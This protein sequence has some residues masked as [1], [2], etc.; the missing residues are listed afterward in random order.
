LRSN[1]LST[2]N[3]GQVVGYKLGAL[4]GSSVLFGFH[5]LYGWSGLY[6]SLALIYALATVLF[7]RIF[8]SNNNYIKETNDLS[9]NERL[10]SFKL[11]AIF[12]TPGMK[13][14]SIFVLLYKLGETGAITIFP[15]YLIINGIDK[16][17]I[18]L[19]NGSIAMT[20]SIIG[21]LFGAKLHTKR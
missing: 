17:L 21:S 11:R 5:I 10:K 7:F 20:A 3:A 15:L 2:G 19:W 8:Y 14:V 13:E 6:A 1:E 12:N 16:N 4:F 9:S 18:G